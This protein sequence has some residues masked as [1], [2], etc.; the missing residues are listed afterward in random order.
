MPK[1][2]TMYLPKRC[3]TT[4]PP[5]PISPTPTPPR[6]PP[7]FER[8]CAARDAKGMRSRL[9]MFGEEE[10]GPPV[11]AQHPLASAVEHPAG[12]D[13]AERSR[14]EERHLRVL[15]QRDARVLFRLRFKRQKHASDVARDRELLRGRYRELLHVRQQRVQVRDFAQRDHGHEYDAHR[16]HARVPLRAR[17]AA[18]RIQQPRGARERD[19]RS[20]SGVGATA[21]CR[22]SGARGFRNEARGSGAEGRA[23]HALKERHLPLERLVHRAQRIIL[24]PQ[25]QLLSLQSA[26]CLLDALYHAF[27]L[28]SRLPGC[29]PISSFL[30]LRLQFII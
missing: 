16:R 23:E 10:L 25:I 24:F 3:A 27:L 8:L 7:G 29:F 28:R 4:A 17:H 19:L 11:P 5:S 9:V 6:S 2:N 13:H 21:P 15:L 22:V 30:F 14:E 26:L 12:D 20:R 18:F 1:H